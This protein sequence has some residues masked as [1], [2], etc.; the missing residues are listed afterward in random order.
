LASTYKEKNLN[1]KAALALP[2]WGEKKNP[3]PWKLESTFRKLTY[4]RT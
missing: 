3:T 1:A 2:F 4:G